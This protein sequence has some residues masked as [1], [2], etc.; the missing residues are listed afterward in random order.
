EVR[1]IGKGDFFGEM[2]MLAEQP[3]LATIMV[4]SQSARIGRLDKDLFLRIGRFN[5]RFLFLLLQNMIA[6]L[7]QR[8]ER[9]DQLIAF[10]A[11]HQNEGS[12]GVPA[13]ASAEP[14]HDESVDRPADTDMARNG[15]PAP[16]EA[17][18]SPGDNQDA[19]D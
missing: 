5:S 19:A 17:P 3:A 8:E 18:G 11:D 13:P 1:T 16:E 7:I 4:V 14:D 2:S 9:I 10:L 12:G 6:R 15:N